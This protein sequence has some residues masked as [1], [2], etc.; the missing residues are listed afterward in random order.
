MGALNA[1]SATRISDRADNWINDRYIFLVHPESR[2]TLEWFL[3]MAEVAV[4]CHG[5][6]IIQVDP[7]NRLEVAVSIKR[8]RDRIISAVSLRTMHTFATDMNCHVQILRIHQKWMETRRGSPPHAFEDI[9]GL[10]E[11]GKY[12]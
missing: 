7:W 5:A 3:D 1:I 12:G 4:I 11:L 6:R 8:N 2:P 9:A 10:E